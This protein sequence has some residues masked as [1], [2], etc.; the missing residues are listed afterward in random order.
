MKITHAIFDL[1]GTLIDSN[2]IWFDAIFDYIDNYCKY[3]REDIPKIFFS[4]IIFGGTYKSLD[5]LRKTMG[6]S[7]AN[8]EIISIINKSV[9][10][11]YSQ[12]RETKK[13]ATEFLKKLKELG[14]D[15]CV[16]TA[17]PTYLAEQALRLAQL[18]PYVDFIISGDERKSGK[19]KKYIFSEAAARMNCEA[20]ECTLFDDAAYS[21]STGKS[22]GMTVI[23]IK[24]AYC[25]DELTEKIKEIGD[26]YIDDFANV[27][28]D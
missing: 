23:G 3:K 27:I 4:N 1:D 11:A 21:L 6:E 25:T 24:D 13:G 12:R 7:R 14:A 19:E 18:M 5:Y 9:E 20:C 10:K 17:T 28:T 8:E 2:G 16:I 22:M 15:I 26:L